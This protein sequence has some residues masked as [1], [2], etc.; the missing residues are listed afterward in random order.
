[1]SASA[2]VSL[3]N[4]RTALTLVPLVPERS[5]VSALATGTELMSLPETLIRKGFSSASLLAI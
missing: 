1:V 2:S 5:I 3:E 4:R